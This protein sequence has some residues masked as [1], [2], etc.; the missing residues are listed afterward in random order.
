MIFGVYGTMGKLGKG[1]G[2]KTTG[3]IT[4]HIQV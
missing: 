4:T 2:L 3:T 1:K